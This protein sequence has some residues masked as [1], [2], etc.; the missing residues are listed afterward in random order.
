[1]ARRAVRGNFKG[2]LQRLPDSV[3]AELRTSLD[4]AGKMVVARARAR[5]PVYRGPPRKGLVPGALRAGLSY[6]VLPK[7][8][9]MR[10]G[11]VGRP[12]NRKLFYARFVE[13]GHRIGY[14]GN[15]LAK[16]EPVKGN[17]TAAKIARLKRRS[18]IRRSGVAPRPFLYTVTRAELYQPFQ[19]VWGAALNRAATGAKQE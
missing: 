4:A 19:R 2:L 11:L 12:I 8:L 9:K 10:A 16:R 18:D 3:A 14:R 15:V 7:T 6:K 17:S 13:F 1:M 5:A